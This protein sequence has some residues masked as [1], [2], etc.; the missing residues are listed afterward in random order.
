MEVWAPHYSSTHTNIFGSTSPARLRKAF[1][2]RSSRSE[3]PRV[4]FERQPEV[5]ER[6][7]HGGRRDRDA[8]FFSKSS[9]CPSK[10]RSGLRETWAGSP[11]S[12]GARLRA[13]GPGI[14]LSST[15]PVSRRSLR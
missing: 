12:S 3:E 1:L 15:P 5:F 13:E 10:V 4:F 7:A 8:A 6:A 9:Q 2:S 11:S 14:G